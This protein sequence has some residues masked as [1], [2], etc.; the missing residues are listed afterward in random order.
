MDDLRAV[1]DLDGPRE[2]LDHLRGIGDRLRGLLEL[3]GEASPL[4]VLELEIG[5]SAEIADAVDLD[6]V[7]M[8][9]ASDRLR[10][11]QQPGDRVGIVRSLGQDHL[12]GTGS[13]QKYL[14]RPVNDPHPAPAQLA[15]DLVSRD[16][17][18]RALPGLRLRIAPGAVPGGARPVVER[19]VPQ[20]RRGEFVGESRLGPV[21]F[22]RL[23]RSGLLLRQLT[24]NRPRRAVALMSCVPLRAAGIGP[25]VL[26]YH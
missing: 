10:L 19:P 20:R 15:E 11:V 23:E 14:S 16:A 8:M 17:W 18:Q 12:Q 24:A 1:R 13:I 5:P 3:Q 26:V 21:S 22:G 9:E 6:N 2:R 4:H 25:I 7:S